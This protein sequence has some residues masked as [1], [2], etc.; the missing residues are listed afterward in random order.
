MTHGPNTGVNLI[1]LLQVY[2]TSVTIVL[3]SKNSGYTCKHFKL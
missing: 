1:K 2:F 3:G